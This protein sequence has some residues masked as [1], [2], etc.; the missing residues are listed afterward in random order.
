M[1]LAV[2]VILIALT[3]ATAAMASG[4]GSRGGVPAPVYFMFVT[5]A[6]MATA[7]DFRLMRMRRLE[8]PRRIARHLWRMCFALWIATASFFLGPPQRLPPWL[9]HSPLR[10]LPVVLV[11]IVMF[12]W[13]ARVSRRPRHDPAP[14]RVSMVVPG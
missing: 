13:L 8:G 3:L 14:Q 9:R 11:L 2:A 4:R 12:Y 1:V 7:G 6:T 5:V 10:P